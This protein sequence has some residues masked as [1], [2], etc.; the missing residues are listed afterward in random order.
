MQSRWQARATPSQVGPRDKRKVL[1][2]KE[3]TEIR[4][5]EGLIAQLEEPPGI[6]FQWNTKAPNTW[7]PVQNESLG[8][9]FLI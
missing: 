6:L 9:M 8:E 4:D 3:A 1:N 2:D 5:A 7:S